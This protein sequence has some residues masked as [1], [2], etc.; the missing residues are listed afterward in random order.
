MAPVVKVDQLFVMVGITIRQPAPT[1]YCN[2]GCAGGCGNGDLGGA[3]KA[4]AWTVGLDR[5]NATVSPLDSTNPQDMPSPP[6][7][8]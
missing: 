6:G 1:A 4:V 5:C 8:H 3:V 2:A 7:K